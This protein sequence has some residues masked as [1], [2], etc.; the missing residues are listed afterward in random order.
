MEGIKLKVV[1]APIDVLN[2][3]DKDGNIYP[4]MFKI[5]M[6]DGSYVTCK[7]DKINSIEK[8]KQ[9]GQLIICFRCRR[10]I[11]Y[12][13]KIYELIYIPMECKWVLWKI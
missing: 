6:D 8:I 5:Q 13:A 9:A 11:D 12:I 10:I 4:I 2:W 1:N 7:I 3:I